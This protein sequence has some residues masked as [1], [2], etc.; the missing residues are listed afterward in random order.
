MSEPDTDVVQLV[1]SCDSR[2][3]LLE[4]A[5]GLVE[6]RLAACAQI[7]GPVT[8]IY[9]WKEQIEQADEWLCVVKTTRRHVQAALAYIRAQHPYECPEILVTEVAGGHA[10]YLQW[11]RDQVHPS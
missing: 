10:D 7:S 8:S 5:R 4:I 9:R 11:L 3:Q 6:R 2:P 1:A